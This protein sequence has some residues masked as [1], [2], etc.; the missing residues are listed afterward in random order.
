MLYVANSEE[1][2]DKLLEFTI[3]EHDILV[4]NNAAPNYFMQTNTSKTLNKILVVSNHVP[5]EIFQ[6]AVLLQQKNIQVHFLGMDFGNSHRVTPQV[7]SKYD[8]IITIGKT[9]Q[10][11][12]LSQKPVYVYDHFGGCG[13]LS[14]DNFEK[15]RYYNFSGRGFYQKPAE[16]IAKEIMQGFDQALD[17]MLS[18][19]DTNRFALDKFVN[20]ILN[21][22]NKATIDVR[23][24]YHFK[25]SYPICEKISEYYQM[26]N[27][28][29]NLPV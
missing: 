24:S 6:A 14:A 3:N 25:A 23:S 28:N 8:A 2:K 13:Y 4:S 26:L 21:T 12:I 9:V 17:F 11:A 22:A 27:P 1:T 5:P 15:A 20:R 16:T 10:Y 19:D 7:I 18:F 29:E